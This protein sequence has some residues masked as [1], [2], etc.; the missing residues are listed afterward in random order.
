MVVLEIEL[1]NKR[2]LK[3]MN[4][5]KLALNFLISLMA[6]DSLERENL[7]PAIVRILLYQS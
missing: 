1:E 7:N 3:V 5:R 2:K 6:S 4:Y